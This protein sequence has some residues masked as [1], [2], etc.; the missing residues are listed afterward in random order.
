MSSL[1]GRLIVFEGGEGAGKSTQLNR[2]QEW[3]GLSG[4]AERLQSR[5]APDIPPFW[6]TREPGGTLLGQQL[7]QLLLD[8]ALTAAENW[9]DMTEL[10]LYAADRAQHVYTALKPALA[11]G[12]LVLCDRYTASTLAY[13]GYGRGLDLQIIAQL[14]AL[15][16][17]GLH[18]DLTL[19]LDID[20][21]QGLQRA[22]RRSH[23]ESALQ[24]TDRMEA[25]E[26]SFHRRVRQG[27]A[28][29]ARA[30]PQTMICIEASGSEE[31]VAHQIQDVVEQHLQQW[32]PQLSP[33]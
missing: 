26:L 10:L 14:N 7:R 13:Q 22:Q 23:G 20:V 28:D 18:S 5:L 29:L 19:W 1:Q 6:A 4:W 31:D 17:G 3:L 32:Y 33:P 24:G 2:L 27:F 12:T 25:A 9:P 15:A 8:S 21:E 30:N 11:Q 16:T